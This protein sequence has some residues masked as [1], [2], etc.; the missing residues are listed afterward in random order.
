MNV[1]LQGDS[2]KLAIFTSGFSMIETLVPGQSKVYLLDKQLSLVAP[3]NY[4]PLS[5]FG[6]TFFQAES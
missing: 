6:A 5:L 3:I 2:G 1:L 4:Y